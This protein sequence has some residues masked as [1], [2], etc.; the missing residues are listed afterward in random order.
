[1]HLLKKNND[2]SE[3]VV[4]SSQVND[5]KKNATKYREFGLS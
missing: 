3:L 1:M 4:T 5:R 2:R